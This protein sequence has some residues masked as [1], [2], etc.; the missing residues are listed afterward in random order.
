VAGGIGAVRVE[1]S[2]GIKAR[3]LHGL[4]KFGMSI[5]LHNPS[6]IAA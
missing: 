5:I 1:D 2:G 3:I 4:W 6:I